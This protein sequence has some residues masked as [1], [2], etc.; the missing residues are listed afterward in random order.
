MQEHVQ[1]RSLSA[2][3]IAVREH[4]DHFAATRSEW[5]KKASYFYASDLAYMCFL[6]PEGASVLQIGCGIGDL[7]ANLKPRRGVGID[8]SPGMIEEAKRRHSECQFIV[9]DAE[10]PGFA[11]ELD[12]TFDFIILFDVIGNLEDC[13]QALDN[14]RP[15][16]RPETRIIIAFYNRLWQPLLKLIERVGTKMPTP[17]Q[18]WLSTSEIVGLLHLAG[19]E[20]TRREWRQLVPA[21]LFGIGPLINWC[22]APLPGIRHFCLRNYIVARPTEETTSPPKSARISI[23]I[24]CRNEKGNIE[25]AVLRIPAEFSGSEIIFVE[26][27]SSDGTHEECLR[28]RDAYPLLD[29]KV[30][31]QTGR[32]K[33]DAVRQGFAKAQGDILLILDADLTMPPEAIPK[34]HRALVSGKGEFINGTRLVYPLEKGAMRPLNWIANRLFS[35]AFS[36]L[37]NQRF[38]DTLC[39]T[40]ALWR[41]DYDRIAANRHYFGDFDPFGDFDLIF[42]ASKL[43]LK[44][45]EIPI[46]YAARRYGAPQIS[47]FSDGLLLARMVLFAWRK[48]K[49]F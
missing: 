15:L 14:L 27:H 19:Y 41:K 11:Q 29:I 7:L 13:D 32:G 26:G 18:N 45:V 24:P 47:R 9:A 12:D 3:K 28:V 2:R 8:I 40:K 6:V 21:R 30:V 46:R 42:G 39:G 48:L 31:K 5:L 22:L 25:Q 44:I 33:G 17:P 4:F 23:V 36:Y 10:D 38:T 16:C 1:N 43:N 49:T 34:F 20:T 35:I 37:L